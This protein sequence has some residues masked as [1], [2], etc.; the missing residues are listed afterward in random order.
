[1][2]TRALRRPPSVLVV[3]NV[4]GERD[5]YARTLRA[6]GY[7][8]VHA[9][10]S[11]A[12]YQNRHHSGNGRRGDDCPHFR[13]DERT[14]TDASLENS[15][16]HNSR[17]HHRP[18]ERVTSAGWERGPQSGSNHIPRNAGARRGAP[19]PSGTSPRR[20]GYS[21]AIRAGTIA[22]VDRHES[23]LRQR[24]IDRRLPYCRGFGGGGS[25]RRLNRG[26]SG[27]IGVLAS[28]D[29]CNASS[30]EVRFDR[31]SGEAH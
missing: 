21:V 3:D 24:D 7:R 12:A 27:R 19:R 14:G 25:R 16:T 29:G 18:D 5:L 22:T 13:L 11:V 9:A 28:P 10:T 17:T 2:A 30:N 20:V 26:R 1:M 31:R 4:P 15:H 6:Y 8:V 23:T